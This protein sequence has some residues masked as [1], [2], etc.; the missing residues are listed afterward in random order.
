MNHSR[1][2]IES[3][4]AAHGLQ[5]RGGWVPT[6]VDDLPLTPSG[7]P[8]AVVW[9]VGQVG[10]EVWASFA[11]SGFL[12]DGLPDPMDRWSK[13]I[14]SP[15]AAT[16]GGLAL[17]PSDGPPW[18]PFQQ[19]AAR[20][21]PLQTSPLMLQMHPRFGLWHAWRFALALPTLSAQDAGDLAAARPPSA[22]LCLNCNGQPCL[23]SCPVQAFSPTGFAVDRCA[24]FL[25]GSRGDDCRQAGCQARRACPVGMEYQY[26]PEHAAFHLA[27]FAART[28]AARKAAL[29]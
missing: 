7:A 4:L 13:S 19:W 16:L 10:S 24:S 21:E 23:T 29:R 5:L 12:R 20:A 27:A 14:G 1:S 8:A 28:V 17:Y 2:S 9:M 18:R 26:V 3:A 25:D 6:P 11:A 15:L 22:D